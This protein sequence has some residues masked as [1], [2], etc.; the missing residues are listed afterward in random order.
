MKRTLQILAFLTT[1]LILVSAACII[2]SSIT[3]TPTP[4]L[5]PQPT[6]EPLIDDSENDLIGRDNLLISLY[7][8]VNPGIVAIGVFSEESGSGLGSGFVLDTEGHIITNYHVIRSASEL[9]VDFPS[10]F[11]T[12]GEIVGTDS[13]SD[14]AVIKVDAP[15]AELHPIPMGD[16]NSLQVG[17]TVVAI[18][19]PHGLNGTMTTGI[20]S[21]LGRTMQS[22]HE[23]PG[24]GAY[25][26]AGDIIQT[27]AAINPGNSGGP[28][29][30]LDGEVVGINVAI[31]SNSFDMGGQPVSS[32][33][34]FAIP[35]NIVKH[36]TPQLI[37]DGHYDYPYIG[38]SS[39]DEIN[40]FQREVLEL[41]QSTGVYIIEIVPNSPADNA[42]LQGGTEVGSSSYPKGGDLITAID[43]NEVRNFNDLISYLMH[44]K[45]P[46][47][48]VVLT[49]I[50]EGEQISVDLTLSKRPQSK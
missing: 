9:E 33:I 41:P 18:G 50:R 11:K 21:S 26:T 25:F 43:G 7:Q 10:G 13:D 46:G 28:L 27:D 30:N 24:G 32:G 17:Q 45:N 12:R 2:P 16:S 36:V 3:P 4:T 49:I 22:L 6:P 23:A 19:N 37:S 15:A 40:L 42:G 34:G 8:Q 48:T 14:I 5:E 1:I 29:L 39:L 31:Q 35:I 38:I 20:V 44:N 47:D